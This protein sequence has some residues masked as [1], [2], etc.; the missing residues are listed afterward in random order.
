MFL[1]KRKIFDT[2]EHINMRNMNAR[3][4]SRS[5]NEL[6]SYL[7][8][9][10]SKNGVVQEHGH[11]FVLKDNALVI[12]IMHLSFEVVFLLNP[13]DDWTVD[14]DSAMATHKPSGTRLRQFDRVLVELSIDKSITSSFKKQICVK[15]LSPKISK[16]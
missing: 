12:F 7:Y 8:V 15:L 3:R 13:Q 11:I 4:A 5:S 9:R 6:H 1:S 16:P 2:C 14:K 10:N